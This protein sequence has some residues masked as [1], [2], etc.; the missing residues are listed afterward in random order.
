M[1]PPYTK[2]NDAAEIRNTCTS[3]LF[4]GDESFSSDAKMTTGITC[5]KELVP[6]YGFMPVQVTR[7][8]QS[9]NACDRALGAD[10]MLERQHYFYALGR[11]AA[12]VKSLC[13]GSPSGVMLSCLVS[14]SA[15]C[16][17]VRLVQAAVMHVCI[18]EQ[19][20]AM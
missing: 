12:R 1:T 4:K 7:R 14:F 2:P 11:S 18:S 5:A 3:T 9:S 15:S 10:A 19:R 6:E 8:V 13:Q 20:Q 17:E 16:V